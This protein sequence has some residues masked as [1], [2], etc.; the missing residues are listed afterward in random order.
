MG[1]ERSYLRGLWYCGKT[2]SCPPG[3]HRTFAL[4]VISTWNVLPLQS[5]LAHLVPSFIISA[6][7]SFS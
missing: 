2:V 3:C 7:R 4:A 1:Q 6:Q 5:P